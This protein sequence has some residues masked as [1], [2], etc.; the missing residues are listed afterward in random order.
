MQGQATFLPSQA[1][2][3]YLEM[4]QQRKPEAFA[5]RPLEL[6]SWDPDVDEEN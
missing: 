5:T 4:R 2:G 1:R 3:F 6:D